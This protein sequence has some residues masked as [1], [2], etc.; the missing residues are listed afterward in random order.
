MPAPFPTFIII[1]AERSG[2]RWLRFNLDRHPDVFAPPARPEYYLDHEAMGT[3]G[4]RWYRQH[5]QG[6]NGQTAIGECS[7]GYLDPQGDFR[8]AARRMVR[9]LPDVRLIAIVRDPLD[10][11]SSLV[12]VRQRMGMLP[13]GATL[14]EVAERVFEALGP[15][16]LSTALMQAA[17]C[18]P[19]LR[20][21]HEAFGDRLLVLFYDDVR[22]DPGALYARALEHIGVDT[23]F[24]PD[25]LARVRFAG[26]TG[27]G[28]M[29]TADAEVR[30][31]V[32][33]FYRLDAE[34]IER[35]T[36]RDLSAWKSVEPPEQ[37][38]ER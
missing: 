11:L 1:G 22:S 20:V 14:G 17:V 37:A 38:V 28:V 3:R 29:P 10:R 16:G 15:E 12:R 21:F 27:P 25:D 31:E 30:G 19:S 33:G 4:T 18:A 7:P 2:T 26:P 32:I 23:G 35:L 8:A 5:F 34:V 24:V 36:G 6:W 13:P 9:A